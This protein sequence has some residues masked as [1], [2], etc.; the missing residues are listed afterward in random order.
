M[1]SLDQIRKDLLYSRLAPHSRLIVGKVVI[2][3]ALMLRE[4][5]KAIGNT[6]R[7]KNYLFLL[8]L[9]KKFEKLL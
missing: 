8:I 1:A 9:R 2:G 3:N 5:L 6:Q 4:T 7:E